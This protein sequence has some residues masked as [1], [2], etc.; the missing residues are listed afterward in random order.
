MIHYLGHDSPLGT[1]LIAATERGL[2]S[3]VFEDQRHFN[4]IAGWQHDP[5]H[6]LLQQAVQQLDAYFAGQRRGF[7]LPLDIPDTQG[8]EFQRSVWRGLLTIPFG[9]TSS[10]AELAHKIGN[11]KA[12]RAVGAAN[13]RNPIAIIVPCHRVIG[14]AGAL[15][16]YAGGLERKRF[17]LA[18]ESGQEQ[19]LL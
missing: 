16:G 4:G 18:L 11:P 13:G 10:Y 1:M 3:A 7:E 15:V 14:A 17:L 2:R 6:P 19:I 5:Q 8:T 12:V 9:R